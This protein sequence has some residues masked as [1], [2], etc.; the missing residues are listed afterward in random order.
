MGWLSSPWASCL[1]LHG[2]QSFRVG[3]VGGSTDGTAKFVREY[4]EAVRAPEQIH[5]ASLAR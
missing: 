3:P 4:S 2:P 1:C 5:L